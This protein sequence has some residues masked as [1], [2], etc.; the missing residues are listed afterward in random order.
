MDDERCSGWANWETW[1]A[2]NWMTQGDG[3]QEAWERRARATDPEEF[4]EA[5]RLHFEVGV[6][7]IQNESSWFTDV[8]L[9]A[10]WRVDW[11]EIAE[12]FAAD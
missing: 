4:A 9:R 1:N 2:F 3:D 11:V 10:L 7:K 8:M 6:K 5:L 12:H